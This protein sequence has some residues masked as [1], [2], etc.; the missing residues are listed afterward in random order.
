MVMVGLDLAQL[1][2]LVMYMR[3]KYSP[4]V[5]PEYSAAVTVLY[6]LLLLPTLYLA[7]QESS[8][9]YYYPCLCVCIAFCLLALDLVLR[10]LHGREHTLSYSTN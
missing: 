1:I 3:G 10:Y 4:S 2:T 9:W 6:S 5:A 7:L 8:I